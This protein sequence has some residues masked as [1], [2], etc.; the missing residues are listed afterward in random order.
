M[1]RSGDDETEKML[2]ALHMEILALIKLAEAVQTKTA[3]V[4]QSVLELEQ[5]LES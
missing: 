4:A 5:K 2:D 1:T 3:A